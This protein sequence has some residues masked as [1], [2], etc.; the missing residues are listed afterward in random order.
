MAKITAGTDPAWP[1]K[2]QGKRCRIWLPK[3]A[4]LPYC[5]R[6]HALQVKRGQNA[7]KARLFPGVDIDAIHYKLGAIRGAK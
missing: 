4:K 6:C 5:R 1:K 7:K 2:C 3:E